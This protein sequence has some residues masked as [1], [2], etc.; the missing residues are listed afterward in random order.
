M[1]EPRVG[2]IGLGFMGRTHLAAYRAAGANVVAAL[3]PTGTRPPAAGNLPSS[4]VDLAG[5][6]VY[7]EASEFFAKA[8]L[9]AVSVCTPTDS[10]VSVSKAALERGWHVLVEKPVALQAAAIRDLAK[11]AADAGRWCIPAMVMRYWPGWHCLRDCI[12]DGRHGALKSL[13]IERLG[14][15]PQWNK[16][17]FSDD[18]RSGGAMVDLHI[19]DTDYVYWCFGKPESVV[20]VGTTHQLTTIYRVGGPQGPLISATGGWGQHPSFGFRMRYLA[21]FER[22]TIEFDLAKGVTISND[23]GSRPLDCG[24]HNAYEQQVRHFLRV[25]TGGEPPRAT[26][27]QAVV[28]AEILDLERQSMLSR[29]C[30]RWPK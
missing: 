4:D 8:K 17:F 20:T 29:A 19:H 10:H 11:A 1:N 25:L 14:S 7:R 13:A 9:D 21:N 5:V 3:D 27:E 6:E 24:L 22:A 28:V 30:G 15:A 18:T 23:D 12:L 26:L 2:I 16:E